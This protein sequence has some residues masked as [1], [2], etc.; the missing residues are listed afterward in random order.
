VGI[1][2][3]IGK[4]TTQPEIGLGYTIADRPPKKV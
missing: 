4:I 1:V 2:A 3:I